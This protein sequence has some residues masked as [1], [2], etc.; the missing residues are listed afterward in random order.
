MFLLK[1][2]IPNIKVD[3]SIQ[4]NELSQCEH[5]HVTNTQIKKWNVTTTR[6]VPLSPHQSPD[7]R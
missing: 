6:K 2:N 4:L 7:P 5:T 3:I 1:C